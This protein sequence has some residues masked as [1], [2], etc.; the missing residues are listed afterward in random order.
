MI[1]SHFPVKE[2]N[3]WKVNKFFLLLFVIFV[4]IHAGILLWM[5]IYP[6]VDL[7]FHLAAATI[8]RHIHDEGNQFSQYYYLDTFLKPNTFHLWFCSLSIFPS[9]EFA[10]KV[11]YTIYVLLFPLAIVLIIKHLK[12]NIWIAL[13]ALILLYNYSMVFGFAGYTMAMPSVMFCYYFFLKSI[14]SKSYWSI[15]MLAAWLVMLFFM[16]A[17][18]TLF[19]IGVVSVGTIF[20]YRNER[21]KLWTRLLVIVPALII[22]AYWWSTSQRDSDMIGFLK[23][24]YSTQYFPEIWKR[25]NFLYYDNLVLFKGI[26]GNIAGTFFSMFIYLPLGYVLTTQKEKIKNS[27]KDPQIVFAW[28]I[29]LFSAAGHLFLPPRIPDQEIL[30]ER[31]SVFESLGA[32]ILISIYL[33]ARHQR[34]IKVAVIFA[35]SLHCLLWVNFFIGFEKKT[36]AFTENIFPEDTRNVRVASIIGDCFYQKMQSYIMFSDY[37]ITWKKGIAVTSIID[38]RFGSVRRKVDEHIL[39]RFNHWMAN[40]GVY[41]KEYNEMEYILTNDELPACFK[42]SLADFTEVKRQG[43]WKLLKNTK[44]RH[45]TRQGNS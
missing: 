25:I 44:V 21:R 34:T 6:F 11:Y 36:E 33:P 42:D 12:G 26:A 31:F 40:K 27:L 30:F 28:M 29:F 3:F 13:L 22:I 32:I 1:T 5:R 9:V 37:Y 10:N 41:H 16:H 39:P 15:I 38:Y 35:V 43:N 4:A 14:D 7:S 19:C 18:V 2:E 8:Y 20:I 23:E 24:Y 45:V 17:L